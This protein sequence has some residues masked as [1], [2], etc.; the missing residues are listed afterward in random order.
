MS[1]RLLF[2]QLFEPVSSTYS[3]LLASMPSMEAI[4]IDPVIEKKIFTLHILSYVATLFFLHLYF[5]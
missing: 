1:G 2:R 5:V 4:I 3:Y